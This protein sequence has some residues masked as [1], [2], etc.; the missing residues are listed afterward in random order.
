VKW[1]AGVLLAIGI[2]TVLVMSLRRPPIAVE[3]ATVNR[4]PLLVTVD[5]DGRTRVKDR[6]T[7]SAPLA[8]TVARIGLRA[9]DSVHRG[10]VIARLVPLAVP[11]LDPRSRLEAEARVAAAEAGLRQAGTAVNRARAAAENAQRDAQRSRVLL[12]A[13]AEAPQ[14][15]ERAEL[16]DRLRREELE[17]ARFAARIAESDLLIARAA[18][19]RFDAGAG[20]GRQEF[21]VRSPVEGRVLR[22]IQESEGA[23]QPGAPLLEIGN[24]AALEIVVD[25]LTADA[26]DIHDAARVAIER[27]GSDSALHGRVHRIEPSAFTKLSALGVEEQRV[28][29]VID[30]D[31]PRYR[32]SA[33]GDGY[34]VEARIQVWQAG[35][36]LQVPAGAVF[37]HDGG[38]AVYAVQGGRARLRAVTLGRRNP[39]Q[40]QI[41]SGLEPGER[42]VVYPG[43]SVV[44]GARVEA[45]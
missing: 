11:L 25:V 18:L 8:G 17:S 45:R 33:L 38:W 4:G 26:V 32:W 23:V 34:R 43:E 36:V 39:A 6:F 7:V 3:L 21:A 1:S 27:W 35:D 42:V 20:P 28:N 2:G 10:D 24:P 29:V 12:G 14:S 16:A 13:G 44:D 5:E 41:V 19:Q 9:G 40:A 37:R 30:L 31:D 22:V 15:T